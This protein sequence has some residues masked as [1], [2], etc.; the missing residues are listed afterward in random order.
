M[1]P[2]SALSIAGTIVQFVDFGGHLL[3]E[4]I[5]LYKSSSGRP[6]QLLA[7]E[8]LQL[9]T[10]DLRAVI[11]KLRGSTNATSVSSG[12]GRGGLG[13]QNDEHF[14]MICDEATAIAEELLSKLDGLK[15]NEGKHRAWQAF[16]VV[17]RSAWSSDEIIALQQRL[18]VFKESL[19]SRLM[20]SIR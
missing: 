15:A 14:H 7:S 3:S 5:Q 11:T 1:D 20:L 4:T 8:E 10:G 6:L 13:V 9:V 19:H 17:V 16:K 18:A 12:Q 2:L